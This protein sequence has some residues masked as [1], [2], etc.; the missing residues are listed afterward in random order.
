MI[1]TKLSGGLGNQMFQYA[2]GRRLA[3]K[4]NTELYFDVSDLKLDPMRTFSLGSF[5]VR[6]K[7]ATAENFE[8][9]NIPQSAFFKKLI[10]ALERFSLLKNPKK[11][12]EMSSLLVDQRL[13][14]WEDN[15]AYLDGYWQSEKYF[16]DS[17]DAIRKEFSLVSVS[18]SAARAFATAAKT[19]SIAVHFRR[20][21]Y[22]SDVRVATFHG[23]CGPDYY[24]KATTLATEGLK[25][26]IL[27]IFTDD[28]AWIRNN[29]KTEVQCIYVSDLGLTD[30][31]E[32]ILMSKCKNNIIAN[33][34]FSWWGAWLN[35]NPKKV[36]IG[37]KRWFAKENIVEADRFPP[38]WILL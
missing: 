11:I 34:S 7:E 17:A 16:I 1:I 6:A 4:K 26:P 35:Q 36:V 8:K 29:F 14:D 10:T 23:S 9:L 18:E 38:G 15:D 3:L 2:A 13:I 25:E 31:E 32:L 21:D 12:R 28:V 5:S 27:F 24:S 30:A 22:V 20:G 33:S 19:N 37:P